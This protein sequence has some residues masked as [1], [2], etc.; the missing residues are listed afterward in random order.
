MI[1]DVVIAPRVRTVQSYVLG[2]H[3]PAPY[4]ADDGRWRCRDCMRR[5]SRYT[6][7]LGD[8]RLRHNPRDRR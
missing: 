2:T 8:R 6:T 1:D 5:L 3:R 4:K 7:A